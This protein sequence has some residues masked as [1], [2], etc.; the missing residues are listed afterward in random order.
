VSI[1][2]QEAGTAAVPE[3]ITRAEASQCKEYEVFPLGDRVEEQAPPA[4]AVAV[5]FL[6]KASSAKRNNSAEAYSSCIDFEAIEIGVFKMVKS[7][8]AAR[9][10]ECIQVHR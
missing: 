7:V 6:L 8:F 2:S 4:K 10:T 1:Q 9:W 3:I 5:H